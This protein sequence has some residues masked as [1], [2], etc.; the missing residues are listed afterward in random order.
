MPRLVHAPP[1]RRSG[2]PHANTPCLQ[3]DPPS[4]CL[5][6]ST[7]AFTQT[8]SR[9]ALNSYPHPRLVPGCRDKAR[10]REPNSQRRRA[11]PPFTCESD[12][13]SQPHPITDRGLQEHGRACQSMEPPPRQPQPQ[14]TSTLPSKHRE[15]TQANGGIYIRARA[16]A[17]W[18]SHRDGAPPRATALPDAIPVMPTSSPTSRTTDRLLHDERRHRGM[19]FLIR[20]YVRPISCVILSATTAHTKMGAYYW[21]SWHSSGLGDTGRGKAH[22]K[23][24]TQ[25][26]TKHPHSQP[27]A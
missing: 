13:R 21:S 25:T 5:L 6:H 9:H 7:A 12:Q 23:N 22:T 1:L 20:L 3:S 15:Y 2:R 17:H 24:N 16:L 11:E 14:P 19:P 10:V 18:W 27:P 8:H 26:Q 4:A